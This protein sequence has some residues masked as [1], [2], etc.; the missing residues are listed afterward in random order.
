MTEPHRPVNSKRGPLGHLIGRIRPNGVTIYGY[1]RLDNL[2]N[3][4]FEDA[5]GNHDTY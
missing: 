4:Q 3:I 2:T 5:T 1:D